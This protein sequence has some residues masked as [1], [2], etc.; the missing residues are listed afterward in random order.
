MLKSIRFTVA[1]VF[2]T[3]L[4]LS[5]VSRADP[6][7]RAHYDVQVKDAGSTFGVGSGVDIVSGV[8]V[9][10]ELQTLKISLLPVIGPS[11]E[12]DLTLSV[13]V[14]NDAPGNVY[15]PHTQS[16]KGQIGIPMEFSFSFGSASVE[17]AIVIAR[18]E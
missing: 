14:R 7:L 15:V 5:G 18:V 2:T 6:L 4:A 16:F 10:H 3:L 8:P 12:Y 1:C 11:G 9:E 13:G 17:G